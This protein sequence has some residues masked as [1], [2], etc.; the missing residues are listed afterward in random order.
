MI[1][2]SVGNRITTVGF[3]FQVWTFLSAASAS[4]GIA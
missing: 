3:W 2:T 4:T 1:A